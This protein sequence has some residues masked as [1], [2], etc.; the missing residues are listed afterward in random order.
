MH[1]F[2]LQTLFFLEVLIFLAVILMQIVNESRT[3]VLL[4]LT[5]SFFVSIMLLILAFQEYSFGLL[6]SALFM[7]VVKVVLAPIFFFR[8]ISSRKVKFSAT[9]YLSTPMTFLTIMFIVVLANS[10][11]FLPLTSISTDLNKAVPIALSSVLASLFLTINRRGAISQIVGILS[12]E[13]S[14]VSFGSLLGLKQTLVLELGIIFDILVWIII[15]TV[16]TSMMYK[17]FGSLNITEIKHLK[18]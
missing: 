7:L 17:H 10:Q 14:I 5:Q 15:A 18:E 1:E 4:Y 11:V 6:I 9:S 16:F 13:N 2:I 8:M 3:I 12:L